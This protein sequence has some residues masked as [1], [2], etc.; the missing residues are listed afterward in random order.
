LP[1]TAERPG[2]RR[3]FRFSPDFQSAL[4]ALLAGLVLPAL[5][6]LA[7]LTG[8]LT[9]L[10]ATLVLLA[11]LLLLVLVV[12]VWIVHERLLLVDLIRSNRRPRPSFLV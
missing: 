5:L 11:A 12:L 1:K 10:L 4:T 2:S 8:L 7:A 9:A 3:A 6:L